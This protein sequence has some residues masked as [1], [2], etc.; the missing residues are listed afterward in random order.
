MKQF[1]MFMNNSLLFLFIIGISASAVAQTNDWQLIWQDQFSKDGKPDT[2]KWSFTGR[3]KSAWNCYCTDDP[4]TAIVKNGQLYLSGIVSIDPADTASYQTGCIETKHKF[5]FK[6]GKLE[7]RAKVPQAQGSWPAIW[8]MPEN[9][10]YGGW[11]KSGEID[12]MEHL[13]HDSLFYQ[14]VHS[15]YTHMLHHVNNPKHGGIAPIDPGKFNVYGME[16]YPD[17]MDFLING[18]KTFSYSR[19]DNDTTKTQWPFDQPFYIILDQALGGWPGKIKNDELPATMIVDWVKV[20]K[21]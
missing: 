15:Y 1:I 10:I 16:W 5:S 18:K 13:N 12:V 2:S 3:G 20:F 14:T 17:R 4:T 6:Y 9:S 11:P 19:I 21:R 7:V 8:L